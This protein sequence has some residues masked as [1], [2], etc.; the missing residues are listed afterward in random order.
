MRYNE[1][2]EAVSSGLIDKDEVIEGQ[3]SLRHRTRTCSFSF[4]LLDAIE[5]DDHQKNDQ[6]RKQGD[7]S[8]DKRYKENRDKDDE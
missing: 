2:R 6:H 7:G 1:S 4:A 5:G 8:K 3:R